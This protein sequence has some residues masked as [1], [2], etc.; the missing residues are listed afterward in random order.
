MQCSYWIVNYLF[1][2]F[3]YLVKINNIT[4]ILHF[5]YQHDTNHENQASICLRQMRERRAR[6]II[7]GVT[8]IQCDVILPW[9]TQKEWIVSTQSTHKI[10]AISVWYMLIWNSLSIFATKLSQNDLRQLNLP[11][12]DTKVTCFPSCNIS[13]TQFK[14][15]QRGFFVHGFSSIHLQMFTHH[16]CNI[17]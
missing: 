4:V 7:I 9:F 10:K 1:F 8:V 12:T 13:Q 14:Y 2:Y 17:T 15:L 5:I 11:F 6:E 16:K 3:T